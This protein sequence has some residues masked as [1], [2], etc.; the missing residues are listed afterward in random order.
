MNPF[1]SGARS[2]VMLAAALMLCAGSACAGSALWDPARSQALTGWRWAAPL[3]FDLPGA[4]LHMRRFRAPMAP[5]DAARRLARVGE[6]RFDRLQFSGAVLSLSGV[7]EGRH[8]MAQLRPDDDGGLGTIGL[9]SSLVPGDRRESAFD[10][11]AL[12]PPGARLVLRAS[13]RLADGAGLLASYLCPGA[14][15]RVVAAVWRALRD[16]HWRPATAATI[17]GSSKHP[18]EQAAGEWVQPDGARLT[19]H[20]YPRADAVAL[21]FW[22]R[23]KEPS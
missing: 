11:E 4:R 9:L 19:V 6:S 12:V 16:R 15:P 3:A 20:L 23:P 14:Y 7:H 1:M 2:P 22:H 21:M 18:A 17:S 8:W 13:S 5:A 10:P